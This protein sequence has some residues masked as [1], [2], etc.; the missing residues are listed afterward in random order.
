M[1]KGGDLNGPLD[2][3]APTMQLDPLDLMERIGLSWC[4]LPDP[5]SHSREKPLRTAHQ[6]S[7]FI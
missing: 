5:V 4:A 7:S 3:E 6:L 1:S 2:R